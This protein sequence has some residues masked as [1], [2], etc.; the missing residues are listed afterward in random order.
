MKFVNYLVF[1]LGISEYNNVISGP[2]DVGGN[3]PSPAYRYSEDG[4]DFCCCA[5]N[6]CWN[7]CVRLFPPNDCLQEV[8]NTEWIFDETHG[9]F[10]AKSKI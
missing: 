9:Y 8:P 3:C 1:L 4:K 2:S 6:C 7:R 5:G 10:Q